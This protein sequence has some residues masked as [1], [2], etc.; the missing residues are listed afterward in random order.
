M[1]NTSPIKKALSEE[2]AY[3]VRLL[4]EIGINFSVAQPLLRYNQEAA[5]VQAGF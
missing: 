3:S 2:K 5:Q 4:P 1:P